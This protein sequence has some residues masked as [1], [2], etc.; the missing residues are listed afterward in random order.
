MSYKRVIITEFGGP[1]VLEVIEEEVLPEPGPGEV[2]VK[3]LAT[4]AT[5]T[6][7]MIRKGKYPDVKEKPP[8]SPG[9][10]VVGVVDKLGEGVTGLKSGQMVADLTVIGAYAEYICLPAS[11]LV[12]V[13]DGLDP[14]EAVSLVLSYVTPYQML[15]RSAKIQR[16]QRILVHGAGGAVGTAMLQLGK[17]L[18]LGRSL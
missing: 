15:H 11:R 13:P 2:R 17:L 18:D 1:E 8:F 12:P 10:D 6:D 5:F 16:G 4:S 7:T 3:V 9:Y 14:A